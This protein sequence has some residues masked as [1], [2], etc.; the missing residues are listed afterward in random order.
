MKIAARRWERWGLAGQ[1]AAA[2]P[3][4]KASWAEG[5]VD[6]LSRL[7][8]KLQIIRMRTICLRDDGSV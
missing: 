5:I 6:M 4:P 2:Q 8:Y 7:C 1:N 3:A